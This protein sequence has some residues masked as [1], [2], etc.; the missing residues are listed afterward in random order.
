MWPLVVPVLLLFNDTSWLNPILDSIYRDQHHE[1]V[2]LLRHSLQGNESG[3]ERFPWPVLSFNEQMDF[4]VRGSFNNEM[5]VLIWQTGNS[6]WDSDLWQALDRSLLNMR[7]VRVL[8]LRKWEKSPSVDIAKTAE[9]LQFAYL[10][11]FTH[12]SSPSSVR[13]GCVGGKKW[14][15]W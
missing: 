3:L 14:Y 2:L 8:L 6:N 1:T 11:I 5:L 10:R 7:K 9:H 12:N 15:S 13:C 4:Y